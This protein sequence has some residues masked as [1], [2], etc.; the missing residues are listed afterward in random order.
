MSK[1]TKDELRMQ[2]VEIA[3]QWLEERGEEVLRTGS[4]ELTIPVVDKEGN[5]EY[6]TIVVKVPNGSR[7]GEPFDGYNAAESYKIDQEAKAE[8]AKEAAA[9]KAAKIARDQKMREEKARLKAERE[10]KEGAN[11]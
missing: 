2:W 8:R 10:A 6:I 4:N 7:D 9:K 3:S 11:N 1:Q 5:D